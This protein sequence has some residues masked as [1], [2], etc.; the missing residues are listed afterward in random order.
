[1]PKQYPII[2]QLHIVS[3]YAT[4]VFNIAHFSRLIR[5]E[6]RG[7]PHAPGQFPLNNLLLQPNSQLPP[8][9]WRKQVKR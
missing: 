4:L 2:F 7:G 3:I 1:L 9:S 5:S 8:E 6:V